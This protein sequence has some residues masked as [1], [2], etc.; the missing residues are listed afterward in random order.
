ML[1]LPAAHALLGGLRRAGD[2]PRLTQATAAIC[3]RPTAA[4]VALSRR[5]PGRKPDAIHVLVGSGKQVSIHP[6]EFGAYYRRIRPRLERFV[7]DPPPTELL[8][9]EHCSNQQLQAA[10]R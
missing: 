6:D 9:A 2:E 5:A 10:L 3:L 4:V 1:R 8:P 7:G